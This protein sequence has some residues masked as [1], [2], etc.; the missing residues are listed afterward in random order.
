MRNLIIKRTK[1]F[2]GCLM[3]TKIYIEDYASSDIVINNIPCRK[4]GEL[5]NGEEKNFQIGDDAAK[6][7][8]IEDQLTKEICNDFYQLPAGQ[9]DVFL[10]GQNNFNL[11]N[12]NAFRFDNNDNPEVEQNRKKGTRKGLIILIVAGIVGFVSGFLFT[13]DFFDKTPEPETFSYDG[14]YVTLTDA[15]DETDME[16]FTVTY[17]SDDVA[18]FALKEEFS[19]AEGFGDRT[20][21]QYADLVIENNNLESAEVKTS[22]EQTCF[23][24]E[25]L[26]P[27]TDET[28]CYFAYV[29][30]TNDAFWLIQFATLKENVDDYAPQITEWANSVEFSN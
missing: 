13:S 2:V 27:E 14:M 11:M 30:K 3:K 21:E 10:S 24:Y 15:F 28:Y 25:Y 17:T 29:Y 9:E 22:G 12:G 19:L 4:I 5:K 1:T 18:M 26:N 6:V 8:V 23:E 20:L 16:N 7:F